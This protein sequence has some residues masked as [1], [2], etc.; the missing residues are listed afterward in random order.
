M[1]LIGLS[2]TLARLLPTN[3][4]AARIRKVEAI[5]SMLT[6][7][8]ASLEG[9]WFLASIFR[10]EVRASRA[11]A[12][13]VRCLVADGPLDERAFAAVPHQKRWI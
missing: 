3:S 1:M 12:I 6:T 11:E 5:R 10:T 4:I 8:S 7:I 2:A 9:A 13:A